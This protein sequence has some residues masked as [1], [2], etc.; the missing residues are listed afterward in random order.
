MF[1]GIER[2]RGHKTHGV[3]ESEELH[4][5]TDSENGGGFFFM[6]KVNHR[7]R[8]K[9][10]NVKENKSKIKNQTEVRYRSNTILFSVSFERRNV[11]FHLQMIQNIVAIR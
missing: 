7:S 5:E 1:G 6:Q 8:G 9:I 3:R 11:H 10:Q 4:F 2:R